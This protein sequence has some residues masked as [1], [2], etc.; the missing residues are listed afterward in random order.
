[1]PIHNRALW[2]NRTQSRK[3]SQ[4]DVRT[5]NAGTQHAALD[6]TYM[7]ADR[8]CDR[9]TPLS[10]AENWLA[11]GS[12]VLL[13]LVGAP[14]CSGVGA[15]LASSS[16]PLL[17]RGV[18]GHPSFIITPRIGLEDAPA[19]YRTVRDKHDASIK[20]VV[21]PGVATPQH[22][23]SSSSG[24]TDPHGQIIPTTKDCQEQE[25]RTE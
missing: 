5:S 2:K 22:T 17:Y 12:G 24:S 21:K 11:P 7:D 9:A 3:R 4:A 14:P 15:L 8:W 20:I 10:D 16:A 13:R 18:T 25:Q 23:H 19:R 6:D 1:M